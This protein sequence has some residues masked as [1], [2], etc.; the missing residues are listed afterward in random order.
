MDNSK[1][2]NPCVVSAYLQGACNDGRTFV[3][4]YVFHSSNFQQEFTVDPLPTGTH[5]TGP[6]ADEQ[7]ACQCSSVTYNSV[8]ACGLCQN[9]TIIR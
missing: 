4:Y 6:Y 3:S 8:S 1:N 5:Y 7:N 2:Q 9:R